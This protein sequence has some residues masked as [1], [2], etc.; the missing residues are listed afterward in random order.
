MADHASII[1]SVISGVLTGGASAATTFLAIFK[2]LKRR[3]GDLEATL[4]SDK[5]DPKTGIFYT[6]EILSN[7]IRRIR[8]EIDS[9]RDDPP[10]WIIRAAQ[11]RSSV[12]ME[13]HSEIEERV[14][15]RLR[16]FNQTLKRIEEEVSHR[17]AALG[18]PTKNQFVTR[19][20]YEA[21]SRARAEEISRIRANVSS[22]N[23]FLRGVMADLGYIDQQPEKKP[24][25]LK[26]G[27][28]MVPPFK[29]VPPDG[30]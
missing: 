3:I 20:E 16:A 9:W 21:D 26:T 11:R 22:A 5:K 24:L 18:R 2:D 6:L 7:D 12:T 13:H 28:M 29:K 19:E 15:A 27:P 30:R 4:G 23:S 25:V 8:R 1:Q 14:E 17:D 10:D